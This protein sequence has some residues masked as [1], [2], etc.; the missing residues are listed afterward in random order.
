MK[1]HHPLTMLALAF[2]L[3]FT[4]AVIWVC[5]MTWTLPPT[6]GAYGQ[7]PFADSLVLPIMSIIASVVALI[8]YPFL[9]FA[10]RDRRFPRAPALL[11]MVVVGEIVLITP[12]NA[13]LGFV[14]SF[15]AY[16]GGLAV[17]RVCSPLNVRPGHCST[18]GYCLTGLGEG[19]ACPE[20]GA[21]PS[22]EA[23]VE[24]R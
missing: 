10:L 17:A 21:A 11:A 3:S 8:T 16:L 18:C 22:R 7:A 2:G 19:A 14:G 4:F 24:P 1:H 15:A 6:D 12:I 5:L 20:C 13:W 23:P 9:Y